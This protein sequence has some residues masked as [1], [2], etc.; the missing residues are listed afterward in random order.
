[1]NSYGWLFI[2]LMLSFI[3]VTTVNLTTIWFVASA[4]ISLILSFFIDSHVILFSVFIIGGI[5]LLI[6]SRP[7]LK[8]YLNVKTVPTNLDRI[9][10]LVGTVTEDIKNGDIGEVKVDGKKWS[11]VSKEDLLTGEKVIV[12]KIN[13]VKLVVGKGDVL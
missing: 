7:L 2:I 8:K 4:V 9:I 6:T 1:M 5:T 3:E 12:K 13:G 11:A 10:G